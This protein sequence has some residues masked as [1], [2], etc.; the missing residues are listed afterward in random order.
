M[1][2]KPRAPTLNAATINKVTEPDLLH[3]HPDTPSF[4]ISIS[5][6]LPSAHFPDSRKPP[7]QCSPFG[8]WNLQARGWEAGSGVQEQPSD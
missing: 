7:S 1:R 4:L 8:P 3:P 5:T 6:T 2:R